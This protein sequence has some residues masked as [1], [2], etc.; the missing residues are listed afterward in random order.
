MKLT[1]FAI[2]IMA[3]A[4][5]ACNNKTI[6]VSPLHNSTYVSNGIVY[7]LPRTVVVIKVDVA[8]TVINPGPYAAYAHKFLGI[9]GVP[10]QE[11]EEY[12]VVS[13]GIDGKSESD[14]T[15]LYS[16]F[17]GDKSVYDFFQVINSGIVIP[18]G[19]F[20][21][22]SST[23]TNLSKEN[24]SNVEFKDLSPTPFIAEEKSTFYSK[25]QRDSSFIRVPVQKSMIIERNNEEKAKE[26]SDFIFSLR[27]KRM[28]FMT[29]DVDNPFDGEALK[30]MFAEI[31]RLE[32]EYLSLFIGKSHTE[33]IS[34]TIFYTPSKPEGESSIAFRYSLSK[35]IVASNDLS[36]NPILIE[37]EPEEIPESY[38]G[39]FSA[40]AI[41]AD[42]N[43][44]DQIYYRIPIN[45]LVKISDGKNEL[46]SKRLL[47]Y[48]YGPT[49]KLPIK[50]LLIKN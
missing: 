26:A 40:S 10:T 6:Q 2:I 20:K 32:N 33:S 4:F 21:T 30:L 13:I 11:E 46:A 25:V 39:F 18:A 31:N 7:S 1:N 45:A 44:F 50:H 15:A 19:D 28:E 38:S 42:K 29:I 34:K 3:T 14:P 22:I 9:S 47:I 35:G 41:N 27:K 24:Y 43:K 8:K 49:A 36:G 5:V 23:K 16:A 48:Q 12:S 37:I 17:L